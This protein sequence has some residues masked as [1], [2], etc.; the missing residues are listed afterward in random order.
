M[1]RGFFD[2]YQQ[3]YLFRKS[4]WHRPQAVP[5]QAGKPVGSHTH[6]LGAVGNEFGTAPR[7]CRLRRS[8][9]S[10][11]YSHSLVAVGNTLRNHLDGVNAPRQ[12]D[13]ARLLGQGGLVAFGNGIKLDATVA[14][15]AKIEV[16]GH[17]NG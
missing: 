10:L 6:S 2:F 15:V 4:V 1:R 14:V 3:P 16:F 8:S 12:V 17:A 7:L 5:F 9:I 13:A 11:A